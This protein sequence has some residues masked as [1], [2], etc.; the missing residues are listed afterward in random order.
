MVA[1][2]DFT[3][4]HCQ[5]SFVRERSYLEHQCKQ[6]KRQEELQSPTGQAAWLL[7]QSWF[8]AMKKMPP[9]SEAFIASKYFRT[10]M[11]IATFVQR[12]SMP[13]PEKFVWLM[14]QKDFPPTMW[15]LDEAYAMYIDYLEYT[16]TPIEQVQI[17]IDT[18]FSLA[19]KND[20]DVDQVFTKIHPNDLIHLV[21]SRRLSPWLLLL[22]K[23]FKEYFVKVVTTE[24]RI[25]LE[26]LIR[27]ENWVERFEKHKDTVDKIKQCVRELNL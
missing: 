6:M 21:R 23:K 8:R 1:S 12:V 20:V 5:K 13:K 9:R 16:A 3:C 14:V 10:F 4:K 27:P 26:T 19:E 2:R 18:L 22:S 17:S 11:N 15:L 24:Q 25:I 7:Y